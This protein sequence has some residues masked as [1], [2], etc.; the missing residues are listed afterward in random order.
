MVQSRKWE[1]S[2]K[3]GINAEGRGDGEGREL[4]EQRER[5]RHQGKKV[6]TEDTVKVREGA[7]KWWKGGE[8]KRWCSP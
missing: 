2:R 3:S 5:K 6:R 4:E 8:L 7:W 1:E